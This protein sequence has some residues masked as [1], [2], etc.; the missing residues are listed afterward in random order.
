MSTVTT[1][2]LRQPAAGQPGYHIYTDYG[3][4]LAPTPEGESPLIHVELTN[5][6]M[7]VVSNQEGSSVTL[8]LSYKLAHELGL[9]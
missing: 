1:L 4:N 6:P 3:S 8:A 2:R 5:V 9:V 7:Q